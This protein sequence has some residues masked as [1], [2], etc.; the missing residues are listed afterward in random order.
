MKTKLLAVTGV[1]FVATA[2][3]VTIAMGASAGS[4][5]N[6]IMV[7]NPTGLANVSDFPDQIGVIGPDGED[8]ICPDG[9]P[10]TVSKAELFAPPRAPGPNQRSDG[11]MLVPRCA[12]GGHRPVW[13]PSP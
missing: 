9:Q 5:P 6:A 12:P 10:L 8:I 2:A 1:L 7:D 3:A 13:V 11:R 4:E